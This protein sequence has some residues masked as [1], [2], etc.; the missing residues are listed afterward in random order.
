L[1]KINKIIVPKYRSSNEL[2]NLIRE[3]PHVIGFGILGLGAY[4]LYKQGKLKLP[5]GVEEKE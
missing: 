3:K 1:V 4:F 2:V 5:D